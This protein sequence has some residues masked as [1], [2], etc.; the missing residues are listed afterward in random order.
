MNIFSF[1]FFLI[2]CGRHVQ[3]SC[4]IRPIIYNMINFYFLK[5]L[6]TFGIVRNACLQHQ[7]NIST[8]K[9]QLDNYKLSSLAYNNRN[10]CGLTRGNNFSGQIFSLINP[11]SW[12]CKNTYMLTSSNLK[13]RFSY[14]II[15]NITITTLKFAYTVGET[16]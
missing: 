2:I 15:S 10:T 5:L 9:Y 6:G 12:Q 16:I 11:F 1:M 4:K 13:I 8:K 14:T 3:K 7:V